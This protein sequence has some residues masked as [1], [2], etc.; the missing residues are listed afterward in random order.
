MTLRTLINQNRLAEYLNK[1]RVGRY[2]EDNSIT[3][4]S[5]PAEDKSLYHNLLA[6][7]QDAHQN[8]AATR[9]ELKHLLDKRQYET[10][11]DQFA[12][13]LTPQSPL[14]EALCNRNIDYLCSQ[15]ALEL[16]ASFAQEQGL[17]IRAILLYPKAVNAALEQGFPE[18]ALHCAQQSGDMLLYA[19]TLVDVGQPLIGVMTV[20]GHYTPQ[21]LPPQ[22]KQLLFNYG[23]KTIQDDH[24]KLIAGS[25]HYAK[26]MW[27]MVQ[28]RT[29]WVG[30][31]DRYTL[32]HQ[33]HKDDWD[34]ICSPQEQQEVCEAYNTKSF[35]PP[36][37]VYA[38]ASPEPAR[39][40]TQRKPQSSPNLSPK[41][42]ESKFSLEEPILSP[43]GLSPTNQY[44]T[45]S[46]FE[47]QY[48][49][50]DNVTPLIE[51]YYFNTKSMKNL[52]KN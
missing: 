4:S 35:T 51:K 2:L 27:Q 23:P 20:L 31:D 5:I 14:K 50:G 34:K 43:R 22:A 49:Q 47:E 17:E 19:K 32:L 18:L 1:T 36:A 10:I 15:N 42:L 25:E 48:D 46:L 39:N 45:S 29:D 11:L 33:F 16:A 13:V 30:I 52:K 37:L 6:V 21:T 38:L 3:G 41:I 40:L 7:L 8:T 26:Q 9:R 12:E 28:G 24:K 44:L